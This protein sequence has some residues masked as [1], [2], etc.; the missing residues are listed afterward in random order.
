MIKS[1]MQIYKELKIIDERLTYYSEADTGR[2][3][4]YTNTV[5]RSDRPAQQAA[6]IAD[7]QQGCVTAF[8]FQAQAPNS[9]T[10]WLITEL[11]AAVIKIK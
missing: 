3:H 8:Y 1:M 4:R 7:C 10:I 2:Q 9:N 6:H 11:T 5:K